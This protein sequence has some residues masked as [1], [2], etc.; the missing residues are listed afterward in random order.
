[1]PSDFFDDLKMEELVR[2]D[3]NADELPNNH[4]PN[5]DIDSNLSNLSPQVGHPHVQIPRRKRRK[6]EKIDSETEISN[7]VMFKILQNTSETLC[8]RKL[9]VPL[10][11]NYSIPNSFSIFKGNISHVSMNLLDLYDL[12]NSSKIFGKFCTILQVLLILYCYM[13]TDFIK[14]IALLRRLM[15]F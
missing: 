10:Q 5:L 2:L 13:H 4:I 9:I 3:Y 15:I 11:F 6:I 14:L 12:V 7:E 8:E 1:M